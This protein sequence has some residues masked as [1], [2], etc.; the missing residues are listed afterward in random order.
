M[1]NA[2]GLSA[3][4]TMLTYVEQQ[5]ECY[6]HVVLAMAR[7]RAEKTTISRQADTNDFFFLNI[8]CTYTVYIVFSLFVNILFPTPSIQQ[9]KYS[10][11]TV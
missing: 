9:I 7:F 10:L 6:G 3:L 4:E 8:V 11:T 2:E 1:T 5:S